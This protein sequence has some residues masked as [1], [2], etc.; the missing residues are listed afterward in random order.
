MIDNLLTFGDENFFPIDKFKGLVTVSSEPA[1]TGGKCVRG[2]TKVN[3]QFDKE[4]I[5]EKLGF[6]PD[7][8]K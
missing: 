4:K 8:L 7:E 3:I 5:I 1:N 6:L 2:D